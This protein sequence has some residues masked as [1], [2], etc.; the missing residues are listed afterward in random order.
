MTPDG[1]SLREERFVAEKAGWGSWGHG[2]RSVRQDAVRILAEQE[3]KFR[4]PGLGK[5]FKGVSLLTY[6]CQLGLTS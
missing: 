1:N 3:A 6:F 2:V 5:P 4:E